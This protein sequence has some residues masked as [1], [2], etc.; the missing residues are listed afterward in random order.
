MNG[1]GNFDSVMLGDRLSFTAASS[2]AKQG[3]VLRLYRVID[4]NKRYFA[5]GRFNAGGTASVDYTVSATDSS[6]IGMQTIY[7][8][9][10]GNANFG[11]K[12]FTFE[13]GLKLFA[14]EY[15][16][17]SSE[18]GKINV[19]W[20]NVSN[21]E[22]YYVYRSTDVQNIVNDGNLIAET[23]SRSY[24]DI[25]AQVG[26]AYYYAVVAAATVAGQQI[27]SQAAVT[28]TAVSMIRDDSAPVLRSV[29]PAEK[30]HISNSQTF[31]LEA[32]DNVAVTSAVVEWKSYDDVNAIYAEL[33]NGAFDG[34]SVTVDFSR[35]HAG[36]SQNIFVRFRVLDPAGN[37]SEWITN[38][39]A[40]GESI[41]APASLLAEPGER[42]IA[43]GWQSVLRLDVT[44]YQIFRAENNGAFELI[45]EA[46]ASESVY[47]DDELDPTVAYRYKVRAVAGD[48]EGEFSDIVTAL[49]GEQKTPPTVVYLDPLRSSSFNGDLTVTAVASDR[50]RVK[51]FTFEYAYIGISSAVEPDENLTWHPLAVITDGIE[52]IE[53]DPTLLAGFGHRAFQAATTID[54]SALAGLQEGAWFAVRVNAENNGGAAYASSWYYAKYKYDSVPPEAPTNLMAQDGMSGGTVILSFTP[55]A[56]DV[57]YTQILRST[58]PNADPYTLESVGETASGSF[59]DTGLTDGVRYYYWF[60]SV[61]RAGNIS[62]PA[63]PVSAVPTSV[64]SIEFK[65]VMLNVAVPTAGQPMKLTVNFTNNGPAKAAGTLV[66]TANTGTETVTVAEKEFSGLAPGSHSLTFDFT[67]PESATSLI[68]TAEA[69][70]KDIVTSA[71]PVNHAPRAVITAKATVDSSEIETYSAELSTDS[72]QGETENLTFVWNMGDGTVKN[73]KTVTH[74]YLTPGDYTVTLTATDQRGASTSVTKAVRVIDRRPDLLVSSITVYRMGATDGEFTL[75]TDSNTIQENDTVRVDAAII[76]SASA[77]GVVPTDMAFL[78]GF[79]L[80]GVYRGYQ[81]ISGGLEIGEEKTVSFT[82]TAE[83]GAQIIKIVANDLLDTLKESNKQNNSK[84]VSYNAQQTDFAEIAVTNGDWLN[85]TT[86]DKTATLTSEEKVIYSATVA[87][88]GRASASFN[89]SLYLDGTLADTLSITLAPGASRAVNFYEAPTSGKHTVLIAADDPLLVETDSSDNAVSFETAAFTVDKAEIETDLT[90]EYPIGMTDNKIAQGGTIT[91]TATLTP[92]TDISKAVNVRFY[93]DG[94]IIKTVKVSADTLKKGVPYSTGVTAKWV[95]SDGVH[96]VSVVTDSDLAVLD[97]PSEDSEETVDITVVKPDLWLSDVS[98]A[99]ADTIDWGNIAS[100]LVR[101]SNRSVAT[102]YQPYALK[103]WANKL[104]SDGNP[105]K[106]NVVSSGNYNGIQ[107]NSTSVQI[108]NWN[109][110][111]SG[112]WRLLLTLEKGNGADF[113]TTYYLPLDW[114]TVDTSFGDY[115]YSYEFTVKD[116]LTLKVSPNK[117][118]EDAD[119]GAN[120]FIGSEYAITVK[121]RNVAFLKA[122]QAAQQRCG[123]RDDFCPFGIQFRQQRFPRGG[124]HRQRYRQIHRLHPHRGTGK[125]HVHP[126]LLCTGSGL[127]RRVQHADHV[128]RRHHRHG[129]H[130]V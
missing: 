53:V 23:T 98:W 71:Y 108:L 94:T 46:A 26:T 113:D 92:N 90:V 56:T 35:V 114:E 97:A 106:W 59:S 36:S 58:N 75:V 5:E 74:R 18:V 48:V 28:D 34:R 96:T 39:Y 27:T 95:V 15:V 17:S 130:T 105:T 55:A 7:A 110:A 126:D 125:R 117:S 65:S 115:A 12:L 72:D 47:V 89:V 41:A 31:T 116:G 102:L 122:R 45:A 52:Q 49:P 21:V 1:S 129:H 104:D 80:N 103:L 20:A 128:Y 111:S 119:F 81:T 101:V 100:F 22:K 40:F 29:S 57:Y 24:N 78:T 118:G 87:N 120:I 69:C 68:F 76:N 107:G 13:I 62:A 44:G 109:P 79:Y 70:A 91:L 60:R 9:Y 14:P 8:E 11:S 25:T 83:K 3:V 86:L 121:R 85:A 19:R 61:D 10:Y 124:A 30:T 54:F 123:R 66:L 82:Y 38:V 43:L 73:G 33:F 127:Y 63:G 6:W 37:R 88:S 32:Y 2:V 93:I 50:I 4:N 64:F 77:F 99:P 112:S 84:T 67:V 16:N 42:K 51:R